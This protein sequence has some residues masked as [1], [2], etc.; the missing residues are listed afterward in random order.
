VNACPL[1]GSVNCLGCQRVGERGVNSTI[2]VRLDAENAISR[3]R[4]E[5]AT[6]IGHL[7][8]TVRPQ[9]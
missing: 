3:I 1:R 7:F 6:A 9:P 8:R 2:L 4:I 5:A